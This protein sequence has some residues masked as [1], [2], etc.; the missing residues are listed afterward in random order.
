MSLK[1]FISALALGAAAT[2]GWSLAASAGT[3]TTINV[4][5]G[6]GGAIANN[7]TSFDWAEFGSGVAKGVGPFG[8]ALTVGQDFEFL[9]QA[10]LVN[11]G[12]QGTGV[13]PGL[14]ITANGGA[15]GSIAGFSQFQF[16]V[17]SRLQET[18]SSITPDGL[19]ADFATT[20]GTISIFYDEQGLLGAG[21]QADTDTGLGFDD[22]IEIARFTVVS[23]SFS[24]FEVTDLDP[25]TGAGTATLDFEVS[26]A[27]DF[28]DPAF[29]Q[30]I[31]GSI[32]DLHFD[33]NLNYPPGTSA[34]NGFH[35]GGS[36]FYP[37]YAVAEDDI[38]FKVD[39]SNTFTTQVPEPATLGLL[40]AGLLGI[41]AALR[42]RSAAA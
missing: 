2:A 11:F 14:V 27:L 35:I 9:Y 31:L 3:P 29:L 32:M 34:T 33:S 40:G 15:L 25:A 36:G 37:D 39:G 6:S 42:R 26:A 16:T 5:D 18:V 12:D 41:C 21:T 17:V 28:V 19:D 22:G 13:V 38:V 23:G 8:T 1:S 20:G 4:L 10:N 24:S 30:G 7:V